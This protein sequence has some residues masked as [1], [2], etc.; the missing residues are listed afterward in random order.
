MARPAA[1]PVIGFLG[2]WTANSLRMRFTRGPWPVGFVE[3]LLIKRRWQGAM[4][5]AL[6]SAG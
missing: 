3:Y 4:S 2:S 5:L 1:V 6:M